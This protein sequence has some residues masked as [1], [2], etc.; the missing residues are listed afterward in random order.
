MGLLRGLFDL[1]SGRVLLSSPAEMSRESEH[2]ADSWFVS[3]DEEQEE[4]F[5]ERVFDELD[6]ARA[7]IKKRKIRFPGSKPLS[8]GQ[9]MSRLCSKHAD[10]PEELIER[11][12]YSWLSENCAPENCTQNDMDAHDRAVD[13]WFDNFLKQRQEAENQF[14]NS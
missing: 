8:L 4:M 1:L 12:V 7:S 13:L 5:E 2:A 9:T 6:S 14:E 11:V 10:I 3:E